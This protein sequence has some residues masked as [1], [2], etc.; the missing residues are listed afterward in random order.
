[1]DIKIIRSDKRIKTVSAKVVDGVFEVRAP[2]H[3]SQAELAPIV[4]KLLGRLEKRQ[5]KDVLDDKFLEK[6]GRQL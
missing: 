5:E 4:Q 3:L 2:T 6:R 1:M